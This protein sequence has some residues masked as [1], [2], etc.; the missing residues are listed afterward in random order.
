MEAISSSSGNVFSVVEV[1]RLGRGVYTPA[2]S[3]WPITALRT[4][5]SEEVS[6]VHLSVGVIQSVLYTLKL[7]TVG[8]VNQAKSLRCCN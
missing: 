4:R 8:I 6:L 7:D 5:A 3:L 2:H 1:A